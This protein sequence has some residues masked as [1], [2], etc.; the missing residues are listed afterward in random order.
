MDVVQEEIIRTTRFFKFHH[1]D[2]L[3]KAEDDEA[4]DKPGRA[5]YARK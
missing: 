3:L 5:S 4:L 2:W 1:H